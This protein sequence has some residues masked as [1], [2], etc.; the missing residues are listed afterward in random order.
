[1]ESFIRHSTVT[2]L[3]TLILCGSILAQDN[4]DAKKTDAQPT[5]GTSLING[6]AVYED[7]GQPASRHRVHLIASQLLLG[8]QARIGVPTA[9]TNEN[10][11][12][13][14][15]SVA[16]GEYYVVAEAIDNHSQPVPLFPF[17]GRTD[18]RADDAAKVQQF[19]KL[20][21]RIV[22]DG[23]HNLTVNIR[24]ANLHF[25][26]ISGRVLDP[27]GAPAVGAS[28]HL[29]SKGEKPFGGTVFCDEQGQY[30]ISGLAAGEYII[31]ASP[32]VV[33]TGPGQPRTNE[34]LLGATF[35]PSTLQSRN[36]PPVTV[37]ADRDTG[38]TDITLLVRSLHSLRG[39]I[40]YRGNHQAV[41]NATIRLIPAGDFVQSANFTKPDIESA[42]SNYFAGTDKSGHWTIANVPDGK[43]RLRV[44]SATGVDGLTQQFVAVEQDVRV[45]G[46]DLE[47]LSIEVS[48]GSRLSGV[49]T[50]EGDSSNIHF[51]NIVA[52]RIRGNAASMTMLK[53]PGDFLLTAVASGDVTLSAFT[54]PQDKFYVKSIDFNGADLL[55]T[56]L[57]MNDGDEIKDVHIVIS[58]K[59]GV[60]NGRVVS[61]RDN[62]PI[63][64][65]SVMLRRV[66]DDKLR[67]FGGK[68]MT[69][70]D[71]KGE[72]LLSAAPG[73]YLV[74]AWQTADG[75]AAYG[76]AMN[77]ASQEQGSGITLSPN[78]RKQ[79]DLRVP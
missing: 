27:T 54:A 73:V 34:G 46:S 49:V 21:T 19:K 22:V 71:E 37:F 3:A 47:D 61:E 60:V 67:L 6:R 15:K 13:S 11:E 45:A 8:P 40:S 5:L 32:P 44:Q 16:A 76:A 64:G 31:S 4:K 23:L 56:D 38:N 65:I 59:V 55:R 78:D 10:G 26:N 41:S 9:R 29:M 62:K 42:M 51:I 48:T 39:A 66:S 53:R 68:L 72:Y 2:L 57:Q 69:T 70:T 18:D 79:L 63:K 14:M 77:R 17:V 33:A 30:R 24:V 7:T 1:M 35:F 28:V 74:V 75:P 58:S 12:F 50:V 52:G 36:S 20:Y 43:Y 25:G